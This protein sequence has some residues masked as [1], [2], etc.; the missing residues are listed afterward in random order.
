MSTSRRSMLGALGTVAL[1][2][3]VGMFPRAS[4]AQAYK[5]ANV[6][7][8]DDA[9]KRLM[10]GNERYVSNQSSTPRDFA[11]TRGALAMGQNPYACILGCADSRVSPELCFDEAA[12]DLFVTRVAGNYVTND[13]LASLEYGVAVLKAQFIMVLGHTSCGA[14]S[15][16]VSAFQKNTA[17]PGHIQSIA[18]ALKPAVIAASKNANGEALVAAAT[19]ENIK[20]NVKRLQES[21]PILR[22]LVRTGKLKVAGGLYHLDTGRVEPIS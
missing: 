8:P 18:T 10:Q 20:Q 16:A 7:T 2:G 9:Q 15:A 21:T 22:N 3:T 13:M 6:L 1:A 11:A 17:F 19:I 12:G 5:P 14:V 4:L